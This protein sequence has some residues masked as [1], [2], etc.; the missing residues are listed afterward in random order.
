[1]Y[2]IT[3]QMLDT[4]SLYQSVDCC[5][6]SPGSRSDADRHSVDKLGRDEERQHP[7]R[8]VN[9]PD[10]DVGNNA[11]PFADTYVSA[12]SNLGQ[13]TGNSNAADMVTREE[14]LEPADRDC[15]AEHLLGVGRRLVFRLG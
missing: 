10:V 8:L 1:M 4:Y 5:L 12:F 6:L 14:L 9:L 15:A 3:M 7:A 2:T 11:V 13:L